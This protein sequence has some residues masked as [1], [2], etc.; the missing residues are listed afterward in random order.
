MPIEA[1]NME[2][3]FKYTP[4]CATKSAK[5]G[6]LSR[7]QREFYEKNGF[8]VIPKLIPEDLIDAC[9]RQFL[10]VIDGRIPKGG[11]TM[12]KDISLR[13]K[14]G[15]T[16][17]RV[18]NKIQ[19]WVWDEVFS[20]Y[21][22]HPHLLDYVENFTGPNIMA[23][24]TMLIN[25][26]PDSGKLTSRH[27]WHQDL[28]YFPFRPADQIVAAWTAMEHIDGNNG[29]LVAF[30]G[31]HREET[32]YQHEYPEWEDGV[33]KMYHGV[34]GMDHKPKVELHMEKG[35]TVFF[36]PLMVHG[37]GPNKTANFRKAISCHFASSDCHYIDVRGTSQQSIADEVQAIT[38]KRG[39]TDLTF[40]DIWHMRSRCVRGLQGK[41]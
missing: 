41:L 7:K 32:L 14:S 33:N 36:H 17:E 8:L 18:V 4:G 27:P 10:D 35:D 2:T 1:N 22:L 13:G 26:P 9:H 19:D 29:C 21:I 16:N 24:H 37:S 6:T 12:M 11:I 39:L 30:P 15:Y 5:A 40:Q 25:K 28:H 31:T 38:Q 20:K 34:R 23:M 3:E